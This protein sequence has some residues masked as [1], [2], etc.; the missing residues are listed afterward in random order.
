M[1]LAELIPFRGRKPDA[2]TADLEAATELAGDLETEV[3]G[4]LVIEFPPLTP[5]QLELQEIG[6][7]RS[8]LMR[9]IEDDE[10]EISGHEVEIGRLRVL[11]SERRSI[12]SGLDQHEKVISFGNQTSKPATPAKRKGRG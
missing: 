11:N 3:H 12:L 6:N 4:A 9:Q 1:S 2:F 7:K 8:R 5:I 10:I